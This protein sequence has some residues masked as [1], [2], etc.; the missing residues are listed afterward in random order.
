V[1]PAA[2]PIHQVSALADMQSGGRVVEAAKRTS[3]ADLMRLPKERQASH[4]LDVARGYAQW[5]KRDEA[6]T[7]LLD[8][9]RFARE[10]VRCRK[11]VHQLI[12]ELLRSYPHGTSPSVALVKVARAVGVTV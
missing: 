11:M 10:E 9:D 7:T 1:P 8:A 2:L 5:G 4:M 6:A 3:H 12:T